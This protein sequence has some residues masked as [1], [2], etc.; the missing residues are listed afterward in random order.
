ML[1]A[2]KVLIPRNIR[3]YIIVI[4]MSKD[5]ILTAEHL[6][7]CVMELQ[8]T[9]DIGQVKHNKKYIKEEE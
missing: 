6:F 5:I 3:L 9:G 7:A 8:F 4:M 2:S 1:G